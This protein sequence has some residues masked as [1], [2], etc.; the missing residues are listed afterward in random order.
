MIS[1]PEYIID[2]PHLGNEQAKEFLCK[3]LAKRKISSTYIF[4]GPDDVG[5]TTIANSFAASLLC[6]NFDK[7]GKLPCG[8]CSGCRQNQVGKNLSLSH[9]L[10]SVHPDFHLLKR[11]PSKKNIGVE[12]VREFI[13]GLEMSSFLNSFKVGIIKQ[14]DRLSDEAANALLKTLE[15]PRQKVVV[16]LV[17][18][19]LN[20]LPATIVSRAQVVRFY[21]VKTEVIY[22]YL[23]NEHKAT[24]SQALK[25]S[26]LALGRPALAVKLLEDE[27]FL[28]EMESRVTSFLNFPR[29]P[30][31]ERWQIVTGLLGEKA[32]GQ[33]ATRKA[34]RILESWQGV[35]RDIMLTALNHQDLVQ[36]EYVLNEL[37]ILSRYS[38][39]DRLL[40]WFGRLEEARQQL[41]ANVGAKQALEQLVASI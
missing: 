39:P 18:K 5:K 27:A 15:E 21:P 6:I 35:M 9:D 14:A 22:H 19:E 8:E 12:Q 17:V 23:L 25:L 31:Y 30:I 24:R 36:N 1:E 34:E 7:G 33:E 41:R 32:T 28:K 3:S 26:R 10:G 2:W 37:E 13:R 4:V 20:G 16:I 29:Q 38:S 40:N 11:E